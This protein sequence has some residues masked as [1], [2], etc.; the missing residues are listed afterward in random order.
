MRIANLRRELDAETEPANQAAIL[1]QV[2]AL[3]EHE[4]DRMPDAIDHYGQ[5]HA[6]APDFQPALIAQ[7]RIAERANDGHNLSALQSEQVATAT[8]AAVRGAALMDLAV[9]SEDWV[10][11]LQEAIARSPAPVA[12][13]LILE[14]LAEARGDQEALR[15][16]LRAQAEHAADASLRAALWMDVALN[17][18]EAG[19]P[20]DAIE[21][22]ERAC[23]SEALV[24]Q[25][26]S[27]QRQVA[28]E[29]GRWDV[30]I[31]ATTSM[32]RLLEAAADADEP[33][34]PLNLS[35]PEGERV[36]MAAFLWQE[37]AAH[38]AT[39]LDDPDA[40]AGY[41]EAALRLF[42]D[43][44]AIRLQALRI[45]QCRNEPAALERASGWFLSTAPAD[46]AFVVHQVRRALSSEDRQ[47]ALDTL[48]DAATRYPDSAYAQAALDV[49]LI[50][51]ADAS[52]HAERSE[53]LRA[54]A[55]SAE[56]D[57]RA[58]MTWHAAQLATGSSTV[59][60]QA[61]AL[62]SEASGTA[63]TSKE[64][65]LR[66]ALGAALAA[67]Q[68]R[69]ILER[70][71]ELIQCDIEPAERA[72]LAFTR[73]DVTQ[74]ALG[75]TQDAQ[76]LLRDGIEDA[77]CRAWAAHV[78]RAQ[79]AW[80]GNTSLLARAHESIARMNAG[81]AHVGHLCAAGHAY[82]RSG[83]WGAAERVLREALGAEPD[84]RYIVMLLADVLRE[85]G[86]PED[87]VSLARERSQGEP[88]AALGEVS[89]LLAGATA[90]RNEN[91][92][93]AQRAYEQALAEAP[94]SPSAALALLDVA[95]RQDDVGARV[96]AYALLSN[97]D[98]GGG[99]PE[100]FALLHGD[101]LSSDGD[102]DAAAAYE[103]GLEH[104]SSAVAAAVALLSTP[105]RLTKIDQRSAAEE[106]L[107]DA[108]IAPPETFGGF[109]AAYGA[110]RGSLGAQGALAGDAWL[111]LAAL[112]PTEALRAGAL[113]QGLR[114]SRIAQGTGA[115]DD[116]FMLAQKAEALAKTHPEAAIALDEALA[117]GDDAEL[118]ASAL[119]RR[120]GHSD[121]VGRGA[122]DAAH[123]RALVDADRGAE[124]VALLS[125]AVDER[126]DDLALW[127]TLRSA[128][129]QAGQWPLVAQACE[130]LA[131][132]VDGSL[133]ADL[134]EEAGVVR[135]DCLDQYPQAEDL[136]RRALEED[137]T[138]D[139]AF[140]RLHD[141]LAEQED[142]EALEALVSNRLALGGPKDRLALLYERARLL[143]GFSDRPG[144]LDVLDELFTVQ[145]QHS[146]ALALAAEV[147]VSLEQW[148]EAIECLQRLSKTGIPEEQRRVAH[149]GA[150]DF[151]ETHLENNGAALEELRAIEALGLADAQI[152]VRI[153]ALEAGFDNHEAALGAYRRALDAEPSH[154][155]AITHLVELLDEPE[156]DAAVS[157]YERALWTRI[158]GGELDAPLLEGLG[159]A[160]T[161]RKDTRRAAAVRAVQSA[162]GLASSG[163]GGDVA[164][165]SDVS[166]AA[167]WDRDADPVLQQVVL[168]AGPALSNE[169]L[170]TKKAA[171][172][173]PIYGE[174]E[175]ISQRFGARVGSIGLSDE[176]ETLIARTG[177]D[178]EI[179]WAVPR[180][181]QG[182][183]DGAGR[184]VA[185]RLAW[186]APRGAAALLDETP[187]RVAGTLA[188]VLRIARCEIG[189]GEP[190]LPAIHVKLRR[191]T[192][193]AVHEAVGDVQ[194]APA[195]LLAFARSLQQSADRAGLL[196]SGDIAA[197]ITRLLNGRV[198]LGT[199]RTSA[200]G[201]DLL[202]FWL[203]AES[204]LWGAN[205]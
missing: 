72:T 106:V 9:R 148:P 180:V 157:F 23:D 167:V 40:A 59:S 81:D 115:A 45:E 189:L 116:L 49:G 172:S 66:E 74:H 191:A 51:C 47:R 60:T 76:L 125:R 130:R 63:A 200:R 138:R 182:G 145:P 68:P 46:P 99:V 179:D 181:A 117:P 34:D 64:R 2:A 42:P 118:R 50:R 176:L 174:L 96:R 35:V 58:R 11:L 75:A 77:D 37:A 44:R 6:A 84:D 108:S 91:L 151:L 127:E 135:L 28:G 186:A 31:R 48:R 13:A 78:A 141:L 177:R 195:S 161:W 144:A 165:L 110:L 183:L 27:L 69:E 188:A 97:A 175:R 134:L 113:L 82:A 57:S 123:C 1:Y 136:F 101:A 65:I 162:L 62:Y 21:A 87:V 103:Q 120:M 190:A 184:F 155:F 4:L 85:G 154:A 25:A 3:Y 73:Y 137:P 98:L 16:A 38:S 160:A 109:G 192:R 194:L 143:R 205:G 202:R 196:A 53:R 121:G 146:G 52:A 79:A 19:H 39:R 88:G 93:A 140:R 197:A 36:S 131:P 122:L 5:S 203:E 111:G 193:K 18:L 29:H 54:Q 114:A 26:R 159:K 152:W 166:V 171:P 119:E 14:W 124:A 89:L 198:T 133:R 80:T 149:L 156:K 12:P 185:G 8:S 83:D 22:L 139:I 10:S 129:R 95:R 168:R 150:A 67:T 30:L 201:I 92:G 17:E 24:W 56:G 187:Q 102:A 90:E 169:R 132:F 55:Q 15:H 107:A 105:T 128:A 7:L 178:G 100:L 199:L 104:P 173:D 142:A 61:Q 164:N 70:C 163:D 170:R 86:R 112:A 20:D 41:I 32:A 153:G 94:E 71:D 147:H 43:Q 126:P 33:S 204:P 158:E